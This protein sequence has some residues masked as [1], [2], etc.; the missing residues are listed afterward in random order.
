RLQNFVRRTRCRPSGTAPQRQVAP[1]AR[2]E[3]TRHRAGQTEPQAKG[4]VAPV[5]AVRRARDFEP[6][7]VVRACGRGPAPRSSPAE[8]T[9]RTAGEVTGEIHRRD[10]GDRRERRKRR[11]STGST[12]STG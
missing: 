3:G 7:P 1:L 10:R 4:Q 8:R 2:T 5:G 12:G 6:A 9:E 11:V